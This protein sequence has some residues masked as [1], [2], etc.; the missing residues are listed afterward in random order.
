MA[1]GRVAGGLSRLTGLGGG[2]VIVGRVALALDPGALAWLA[3]GRTVVLVSGTNGKTT[4]SHLLAGALA[5]AGA[6]AHNASGSNMADGAV[7]A[8]AAR[9]HA[10]WAVLEV[11]ELHLAE[12]AGA[13]RPA[14]V[15]LLNLT[16]DQL[17]RVSEVR[18]TAA[19]VRRVLDAH[20]TTT[21]VA[22]AD[23]PLTVWAA[24][25]ARSP[26]WVA[27]GAGWCRDTASCPRCGELLAREDG[28][29]EVS[30][31]GGGLA[32]ATPTRVGWSCAP[33]GLAR[34]RPAWWWEHRAP[35]RALAHRAVAGE[36]GEEATVPVRTGLPGRVNVANAVVALAT[37]VT[38]GVDPERAAAGVATVREVAG[39]YRLSRIGRHRVRL[40]LVKNPA[41]WLAALD[42]LDP[43]RPVLVVV[44]DREA[45]G[46]DVS[47]L[48]D[49]D[50]APLEGRP[51][52]VAGD[53]AADLG[54]RLSYGGVDHL[55]G[56]DPL[57]ALARLP[58]GEVDV[59]A[60]YT[61]FSALRAELARAERAGAA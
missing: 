38:L 50:V 39:R 25:T 1:A 7:T 21:T 19:D 20:P 40:V 61:A 32:V 9:R 54:V 35:M 60:T 17:D 22:N 43:G 3:R 53:R 24:G 51:V 18:R 13:T 31:A 37:A 11:D 46:R 57:A 44:N 8:L 36:A 6:V 23:D 52:A 10:P 42:L 45:D 30:A 12:V 56:A 47:W 59:L 48:W 29:A 5:G 27:A 2:S 34:P 28:G 41:G 55:T 26:V 4:T 49:L 15:V 14:A 33:C 58:A 16:R